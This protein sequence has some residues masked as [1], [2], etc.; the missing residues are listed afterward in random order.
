M[1]PKKKP[2]NS[3]SHRIQLKTAPAVFLRKNEKKNIKHDE[4]IFFPAYFCILFPE[5]NKHTNTN[6]L[7]K[8]KPVTLFNI[9]EEKK[10]KTKL[11]NVRRNQWAL[12]ELADLNAESKI[13]DRLLTTI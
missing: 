2:Y 5:P 1:Y 10:N 4:S 9:G 13:R 8:R 11:C 7:L 6:I 3:N 12:Y